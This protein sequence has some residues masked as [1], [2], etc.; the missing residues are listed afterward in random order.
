[1]AYYYGSNT[2]R[3]YVEDNKQK[4]KDII[5]YIPDFNNI[6]KDSA[7]KNDSWIYFESGY[8]VF[9]NDGS[10]KRYN[11]HKLIN[12]RAL[13]GIYGKGIKHPMICIQLAND[14][15]K[16]SNICIMFIYIWICFI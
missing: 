5:G 13:L 1:M 10:S 3:L 8:N 4:I 2:T 7:T 15:S 11:N 9:L 14:I 16:V 6:S 12:Y